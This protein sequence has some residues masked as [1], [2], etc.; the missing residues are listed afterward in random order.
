[1]VCHR[2]LSNDGR[3]EKFV[4]DKVEQIH[5]PGNAERGPTTYGSSTKSALLV[6]TDSTRVDL[7]CVL[8]CAERGCRWIVQ[9][10]CS[11]A[12]FGE[13]GA[14]SSVHHHF[15]AGW[16]GQYERSK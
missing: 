3:L 2:K 12:N 13:A 9:I 14:S 6:R 16:R 4:F 5:H 15:A 1:M 8:V 10:G 11:F 7:N